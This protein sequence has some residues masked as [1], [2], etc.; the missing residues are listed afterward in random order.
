VSSVVGSRSVANMLAYCM[1][2]SALNQLTN[3]VALE[4]A[5]NGVRVNSV[6][7][8]SIVTEVFS[9]PWLPDNFHDTFIKQSK[10]ITPIGRVEQPDE[11]ARAIAFL[12][13]DDASFITGAHLFVDGG[14][15]V[16]CRVD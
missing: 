5:A 11:V 4:L 3:C 14:L 10:Q 15:S 16:T 2:K 7:P 6:E 13:S 12:A 1:S 9:R 8:G